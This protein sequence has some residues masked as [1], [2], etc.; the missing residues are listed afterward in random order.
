MLYQWCMHQFW[1]FLYR[2]RR[3]GVREPHRRGAHRGTST[4][5]CLPGRVPGA[6]QPALHC[7]W[8]RGAPSSRLTVG[9][10]SVRFHDSLHIKAAFFWI[11]EQKILLTVYGCISEWSSKSKKALNFR[12]KFLKC[13]G[14][15]RWKVQVFQSRQGFNTKFLFS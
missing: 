10:V 1:L 4:Q 2:E 7:A 6:G 13:D 15:S 5:T 12:W 3:Q 9:A 8:R 14:M 11:Q